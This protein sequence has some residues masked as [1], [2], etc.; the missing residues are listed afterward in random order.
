M[1]VKFNNEIYQL[2]ITDHAQERMSTR[3]VS[4]N[5]IVE[6]LNNGKII[7]KERPNCYWVYKKFQKR[8]DNLVCLSISIESPFLIVITTLINWRPH[9][10]NL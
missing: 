7:K 6:I 9:E 8:K 10:D 2:V 4:I 1:K 3:R 5:D